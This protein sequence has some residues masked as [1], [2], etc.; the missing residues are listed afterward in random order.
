M[1]KDIS[2]P[3][4][5]IVIL[6]WNGLSDTLECL[7]SV[8][9]IDYPSFEVIVVDNGST[10]GSPTEIRRQHPEITVLETGKNLGYAEG[11][12][13]GIRYAVDRRADFVFL[14]NNDTIVDSQ[15]LNSF[16]EAMRLYPEAGIMGGKVYYYHTPDVIWNAG[17][18]WNETA[19]DFV[20]L[21]DNTL[22]SDGYND[23]MRTDYVVGCSMFI[24]SEVFAK[25]GLLAPEFFLCWEEIDLCVRAKKAGFECFFIPNAKIWHK[26]GA[27][28][29]EMDSP[30][31]T[32]FNT[33]NHLLWAKRNLPFRRRLALYR[34]VCKE[35]VPKFEVNT[36]GSY[37]FFKKIYWSL[38][39]Y[40][41][42]IKKRYENPLARAR[43][44]GVR[45]YFLSRFGD[46]P[47][48]LR[49]LRDK[50]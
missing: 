23:I 19:L 44:M 49:Q 46:C 34:M 2:F 12:N 37:A 1:A 11:N 20:L 4:I 35:L 5:A 33:R 31:R 42:Q 22:D 47:P 6:N 15:I 39:Q 41:R 14:L 30:V 3:G 7:E 18:H 9:E 29:G 26:I 40:K 50:I 21:G 25:I 45:D 10:D 16:L 48:L 43:L 28:L 32:Y 24:R 27:S 8:K 38:L 17:A 13:V 36:S